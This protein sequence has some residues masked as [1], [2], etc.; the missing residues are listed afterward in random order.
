MIKLRTRIREIREDRD[1]SQKTIA[2]YLLCDQSL[3]SKY[4][5]EKR[6]VPLYVIVKLASYYHTSTDYLLYLTDN[7]EPY[8]KEGERK[9]KK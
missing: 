7:P 6:E 9:R 4:E 2:E 3:Y 1:I 5:L 8:E